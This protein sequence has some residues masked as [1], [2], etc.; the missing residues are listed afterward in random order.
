MN[1]KVAI[2]GTGQMGSILAHRIPGSARKVIIGRRKAEAVELA[3]EVGGV[4][5]DQMSAVRGCRVVFLAVP[6]SA[7]QQVLPEIQPHLD[8]GAL[9]VNMA[10]NLMTG[11]IGVEGNLRLVAA[12]VI[13]HTREMKLGSPGVVVLDRVEPAE[14]ELLEPL[15][16][17]LGPVTRGDERKVM[18]ANTA[19]V[20]VMVRAEAELRRR[21]EEAGLDAELVPVAIGSAA[22][23]VL[24]A[25]ARGELGPF[26]QEIVR[27]MG[28]GETAAS[29]VSH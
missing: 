20:E 28:A 26:A 12:K 22:P 15:L 29:R 2:I 11:E 21:L 19:V 13:G 3:D 6:G 24:R 23:G 10:T 4:A 14:E 5:S 17:G 16:E 1:Y 9:V 7:I 27:K 18:A 25:V 8:P